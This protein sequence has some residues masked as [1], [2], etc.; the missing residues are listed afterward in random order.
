MCQKLRWGIL[1]TGQIAKVFCNAMRFSETSELR[2]VASTEAWRA[3]KLGQFSGLSPRVEH[4]Y[5]NLLRSHDVDAVYIANLNHQ[6]YPWALAS[7]Q[8]GKHTLV[9]KPITLNEDQLHHL[10]LVAQQNQRIL[11]EAFMYR[12]HPQLDHLRSHI[13]KETIGKVLLPYT[14]PNLPLTPAKLPPNYP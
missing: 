12:C 1:G 2:A 5:E 13:E 6:H 14:T 9:E 7:L 4:G 8:A 11:M 3:D 10:H